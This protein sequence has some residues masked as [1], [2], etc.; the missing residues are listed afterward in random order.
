MQVTCRILF[1]SGAGL[2]WHR[3]VPPNSLPDVAVL[4]EV[5]YRVKGSWHLGQ[6]IAGLYAPRLA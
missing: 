4:R 2:E 5:C 3:S 6:M 1:P